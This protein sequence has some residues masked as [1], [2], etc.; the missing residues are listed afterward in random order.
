MKR[1]FSV[2]FL[3]AVLFEPAAADDFQ[4]VN[5]LIRTSVDTVLKISRTTD[6]DKTLK[7]KQIMDVVT[8]VF[9]L[10]LM[11]KLTLGRS[12]WEKLNSGQREEFTDLFIKQMQSIYLGQV[13]LAADAEVKFEEPF[14]ANN[15]M[16]AHT[17]KCE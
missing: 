7:T 9:N 4:E 13:E 12:H 10:P 17:K 2:L 8:R 3:V 5:R 11:A 14:K 1:L 6:I 15:K 16:L